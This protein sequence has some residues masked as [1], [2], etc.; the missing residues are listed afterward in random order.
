MRS[1][2]YYWENSAMSTKRAATIHQG[3][4]TKRG[5]TDQQHAEA[6][7]ETSDSSGASWHDIP[8]FALNP[9]N[10]IALQR[11][12]GNHAVN[13]LLNPR[14]QL[15]RAA[16]VMR[17]TT[18]TTVQRAIGMEF[19]TT[20][21]LIGAKDYHAEVYDNKEFQ[22]KITNDDGKMEF[23]TRPLK[24]RK[25]FVQTVMQMME[26]AKKAAT[27]L[28]T[29]KSDQQVSIGDLCKHIGF[30]SDGAGV[31]SVKGGSDVDKLFNA[32]PQVTVGVPL[33]KVVSLLRLAQSFDLTEWDEQA[34]QSNNEKQ[35][36]KLL[37]DQTSA[38]F[39]QHP[40]KI[41]PLTTALQ[42]GEEMKIQHPEYKASIDNAVGLMAL[43]LRYL[44]DGHYKR[45]TPEAKEA[46]EYA[47]AYFPVMART[48]FVSMYNSVDDAGKLFTPAEILR[49]WEQPEEFA[50]KTK[51]FYMGYEDKSKTGTKN[52]DS[53][54][55]MG[56]TIWDWLQSIAG[57]IQAKAAI[58]QTY[59]KEDDELIANYQNSADKDLKENIE[60][61][62]HKDL[63][64]RGA[65]AFSSESM[66]LLKMDTAEGKP[67]AVLEFRQFPTEVALQEKYWASLAGR[68]F[69]FYMQ[70]RNDKA[71]TSTALKDLNWNKDVK[72]IMRGSILRQM[73]LLSNTTDDKFNHTVIEFCVKKLDELM[74]MDDE[75]R[76]GI[77]KLIFEYKQEIQKYSEKYEATKK[78]HA[79]TIP[80][81]YFGQKFQE[82][83]GKNK[84][85][86][87]K[88]LFKKLATRYFAILHFDILMDA[89][90]EF[91]KEVEVTLQVINNQI[92]RGKPWGEEKDEF[93]GDTATDIVSYNERASYY[94]E[95]RTFQDPSKIEASPE[96]QEKLQ[97][98]K[99]ELE[100]ATNLSE[101]IKKNLDQAKIVRNDPAATHKEA[102]R[103]FNEK[104]NKMKE[105]HTAEIEQTQ[106][107]EALGTSMK[108]FFKAY[109][110]LREQYIE[111]E[112][113][114]PG[115]GKKVEG[116]SNLKM[117]TIA[118]DKPG[119]CLFNSVSKMLNGIYTP[120]AL[121]KMTAK[122]I[123]S[124]PLD[125]VDKL[126]SSGKV[127]DLMVE[128]QQAA[129][130]VA[131]DGN[132]DANAGELAP[133]AL[134]DV[135]SDQDYRLVILNSDGS[136]RVALGSGSRDIT[137]FYNGRDHYE[138]SVRP[139][140]GKDVSQPSSGL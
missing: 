132:W 53:N 90:D 14:T 22:W 116:Q 94:H 58:N 69:D 118:H 46:P 112:Q 78:T 87:A 57:D 122:R 81:L 30:P 26:F 104:L 4:F 7:S 44:N 38:Q 23:V 13:S 93:F 34:K 2:V 97:G 76:K 82:L 67:L 77:T 15:P 123:D 107:F 98:I 47:K 33:D 114:D 135:L 52:S 43:V 37:Y 83:K 121:R 40:A 21:P 84:L 129:A 86:D 61:S 95:H 27:H 111:V 136:L 75:D 71:D 137:I 8:Q 106:N 101:H 115:I 3:Q 130:F 65:V 120:A 5:L 54:I 99:S 42:W 60:R 31:Y 9:V 49:C 74:K 55:N 51:I 19:E 127:D 88:T 79:K 17:P 72:G 39:W 119:N 96:H 10:I 138:P 109:T 113:S 110:K 128:M 12:V 117:D 63:L 48:D 131:E 35:G 25:E 91:N 126:I 50:K 45:P 105:L 70:A 64:S 102:R 59:K 32:K 18:S 125:Y 11:A 140:N 6:I 24:D 56:P 139:A 66:G 73:D 85:E 16:S 20:V 92:D 80:T 89:I 133:I 41:D 134:A 62:R 36:N 1:K 103:E 124:R 29:L 100:Q 28:N 108:N 68:L